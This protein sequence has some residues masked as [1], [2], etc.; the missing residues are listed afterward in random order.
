MYSV[1]VYVSRRTH[2]NR[3]QLIEHMEEGIRNA[4][5]INTKNYLR[6]HLQ[7]LEDIQC[8]FKLGSDHVFSFITE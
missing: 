5:E 1:K 4:T 8:R 3:V 2:V 7:V 6:A